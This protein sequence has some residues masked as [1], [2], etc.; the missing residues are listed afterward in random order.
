MWSSGRD[1]YEQHTCIA[2]IVKSKQGS[3][4]KSVIL[5]DQDVHVCGIYIWWLS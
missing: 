4:E 2:Y 3:E 5:L 1:K